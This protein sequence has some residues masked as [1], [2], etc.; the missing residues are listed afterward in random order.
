MRP[1]VVAGQSL[2]TARISP[3]T[4]GGCE[5]KMRLPSGRAAT[6]VVESSNHFP[7]CTMN[8]ASMI[9]IGTVRSN[10]VHASRAASALA[11]SS[12]KSAPCMA[13]RIAGAHA[14][15]TQS[16]AVEFGSTANKRESVC[17]TAR[18][19]DAIGC[20][21]KG[22][23]RGTTSAS[24]TD[25]LAR[26]VSSAYNFA[27]SF[28]T[29][30]AL[31]DKSSSSVSKPQSEDNSS[32]NCGCEGKCSAAGRSDS[33]AAPRTS[34]SASMSALV[35]AGNAAGSKSS[36]N[37]DLAARMYFNPSNAECRTSHSGRESSV[38]VHDTTAST[39]SGDNGN[40]AAPS[41]CADVSRTGATAPSPAKSPNRSSAKMHN[42]RT[43]ISSSQRA[44]ASRACSIVPGSSFTPGGGAHTAALAA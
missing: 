15:C 34:S 31:G 6:T 41:A 42:K 29:G 30:T 7:P 38:S 32:L 35:A 1:T 24:C 37:S 39:A 26:V 36:A 28:I 17:H 23:K 9:A 12:S 14:S 2:A 33:A 43:H 27:M 40:N 20:A 25:D 8:D 5:T 16:S 18:R 22:H 3:F 19:T 21:A 13:C 11:V 44:L 4:L 10:A